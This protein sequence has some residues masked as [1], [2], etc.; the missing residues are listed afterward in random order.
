MDEFFSA[1][2][3]SSINNPTT[4][5]EVARLIEQT[6]CQVDFGVHPIILGDKLNLNHLDSIERGKACASVSPF[7]DQAVDLGAQRFVLL[8]G[9]DPGFAKRSDAI[10]A[11]IESLQC[12]C[13]RARERQL[14][15]VL[16]TFDR[17]VD[18]KALIGPAEEAAML[19]AELRKDFADFGLLYDMGHM[20]L[21]NEQPVAALN[22]LKNYLVHV[23]AGNCVKV[24]GRACHGDLHPRF[25]FP[26]SENDVPE[27]AAFIQALFEVGYLTEGAAPGRRPAVGFE[28]KPQ[29]G[30]SSAAILANIKRSWRDAWSQTP[31]P[32]SILYT[33]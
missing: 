33:S 14:S 8:S 21:L 1:I 32:P 18:K 29:P 25:G 15:V 16:E 13:E 6:H 7:L 20:V 30:E 4:R 26:G 9:P 2:E 28:V 31:N 10:K 27:L 11:L 5:R 22:I 19:A 3:V 23:H 17:E 24:A 12:L